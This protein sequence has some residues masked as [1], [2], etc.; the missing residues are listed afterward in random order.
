M[1]AELGFAPDRI[2]RLLDVLQD[3]INR[4]RLPGCVALIARH[5]KVALFES[6]GWQQADTQT[7][8]TTDSVFRIYSM[9]K[10]IVSVA[11]M[12][13]YEQGK[14]LL[15]DPVRP[16][17]SNRRRAGCCRSAVHATRRS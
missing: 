16:T 8:M 12:M 17:A 9:T 7:P 14:V 11:L 15:G 2:Q 6:L 10:P 13:L 1:P 5:G 3:E 4:H